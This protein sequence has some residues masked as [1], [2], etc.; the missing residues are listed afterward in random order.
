M[1]D[2]VLISA[3]K[4]GSHKSYFDKD[5]N[6][7]KLEDYLGSITFWLHYKYAQTGSFFKIIW[8]YCIT[9]LKHN[10]HASKNPIA[11]VDTMESYFKTCSIGSKFQRQ[12]MVHSTFSCWS[13]VN[14]N[15]WAYIKGNFCRTYS[16]FAL[17][18]TLRYIYI[19]NSMTYMAAN[20]NSYQ[21]NN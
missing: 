17:R 21:T 1:T 9:P 6:D 10:S 15:Y 18:V 16:I 20:K 5:F 13:S 2:T 7:A 4:K 11:W 8:S 12:G 14:R 19:R 3:T